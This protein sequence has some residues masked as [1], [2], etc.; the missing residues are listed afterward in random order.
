MLALKKNL[1]LF[2]FCL[3][4]VVVQAQVIQPAAKPSLK[5]NYERLKRI[6]NLINDYVQQKKLVGAVTLVVKDG[7]VIQ[8]QGYG[9][10]DLDTK[11]PMAKDGIFRIASQTKA[12]T[13]VGIMLLMEEGK[14]LLSDPLYKFIPSFKKPSVLAKFNEKDSSYTTVPAKRDITIKDLLTHTSG[15]GYATIG[16]PA[17]QAI[18]AKNNITAGVGEMKNNL[19][20][21]MTRLGALPLEY[22]PGER[23]NYSLSTDVLGRVI[24]VVSGMDLETFFQKRIFAPLGMKDSYFNLPA[25]KHS[26]LTVIYTQDSLGKFFKLPESFNVSADFPN[27]KKTYFSGG[28]G[29]SST[30]YDYAIFLQMLLNKGKYNGVT[31]LSPRTVE[32]MTSN[33]IGKLWGDGA[34]GLGFGITTAA[35]ADDYASVGTFSWGGAFATAYW[36]DPKENLI[37]LLMTQQLPSSAHWGEMQEKFKVAVYQALK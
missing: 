32:M 28:G 21:A 8:Y 34:F 23:W 3:V 10:D 11:K 16:S 2:L 12:I 13:S 1:I 5:V 9:L 6:D 26:R 4:S 19:G 37:Y 22:Q 20:D 30:A 7:Q 17:M 25:E 35:K 33:Q 24:E 29:L 14:I 15:L 18:Y 36:A 31:L 27:Q